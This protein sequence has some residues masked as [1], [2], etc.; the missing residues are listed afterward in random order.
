M[1]R[2]AN[3]L[4]ATVS[5]R[6]RND[7]LAARLADPQ[8]QPVEASGRAHYTH[9]PLTRLHERVELAGS[10]DSDRRV[11]LSLRPVNLPHVSQRCASRRD[12]L[13][14]RTNG[15]L[16][17][18][19]TPNTPRP[20]LPPAPDRLLSLHLAVPAASGALDNALLSYLIPRR[21]EHPSVLRLQTLTPSSAAAFS[22]R[23]GDFDGTPSSLL[24]GM[25][26]IGEVSLRHIRSASNTSAEGARSTILTDDR[27]ARQLEVCWTGKSL[28]CSLF[29]VTDRFQVLTCIAHESA[30]SNLS[31]L[32]TGRW[33]E[34]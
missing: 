16:G 1:Q 3:L 32:A 28:P 29:H 25:G 31:M 9:R 4:S 2:R 33:F 14:S 8:R 11:Q 23:T 12:S 19:M 22:M 27:S 30:S 34:A 17:H 6:A 18:L 15:T 21:A 10:D 20:P 26:R 13:L 24:G 7:C 5:A